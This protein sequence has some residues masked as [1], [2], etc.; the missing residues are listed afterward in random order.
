MALQSN[1]DLRFLNVLL[2]VS[3]DFD[4]SNKKLIKIKSLF[5]KNLVSNYG[6]DNKKHADPGVNKSQDFGNLFWTHIPYINKSGHASE[7]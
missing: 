1:V 3:S 5:L 2:P 6:R 7:M 4:L